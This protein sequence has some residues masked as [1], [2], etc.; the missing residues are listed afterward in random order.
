M[1]TKK[2]RVTPQMTAAGILLT[3]VGLALIV[4]LHSRGGVLSAHY[5]VTTTDGRVSYLDALGWEVDSESETV[6]E[7]TLP[8]EFNGIFEDYNELQRQQGFDLR[9]YAGLGC[10]VYSYQVTNYPN[11][12]GP[13]LAQLYLYQN[14]VIAGDIH[15]T[16]LDGFMHGIRKE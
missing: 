14:R 12:D 13:V 8:R 16:A 4:L 7:I 10:T 2:H 15:A 6:Q 1:R 3:A 9:P 11:A 5:N